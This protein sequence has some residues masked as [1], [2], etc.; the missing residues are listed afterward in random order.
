[1][2]KPKRWT[3]DI[4]LDGLGGE[5]L[6]LAVQK[7][8]L[9]KHVRVVGRHV[10]DVNDDDAKLETRAELEMTMLAAVAPLELEQI[11]LAKLSCNYLVLGHHSRAVCAHTRQARIRICRICSCSYLEF[12]KFFS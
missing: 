2:K 7:V 12:F 11:D 5:G 1:M 3:L 6:V 8:K 4:V 10:A 9:T